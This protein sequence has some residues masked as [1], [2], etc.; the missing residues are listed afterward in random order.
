MLRAVGCPYCR[1]KFT[2]SNYFMRLACEINQQVKLFRG[3]L[4]LR[5]TH[6]DEVRVDINAKVSFFND[7]SRALL[8]RRAPKVGADS[9][10]QFSN[11]ERFGDVIV[12]AGIKGL[13]LSTLF[14]FNRKHNDWS[15]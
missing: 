11:S 7:S 12:R 3:K 6:E 15:F 1:Q 14:A 2:V 5:S 10:E 4:D 13:H 9:R 8:P